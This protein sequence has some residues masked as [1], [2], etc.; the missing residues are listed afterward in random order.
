MGVVSYLLMFPLCVMK[1]CT[2][3]Y[4]EVYIIIHIFLSFFLSLCL[5]SFDVHAP[6]ES[7]PCTFVHRADLR[8]RTKLLGM[9]III[10][11]IIWHVYSS[12]SIYICIMYHVL[13]KNTK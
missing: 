5:G 4:G 8:Q 1:V 6:S 13:L 2:M 3:K 12:I 7:K 9:Y 11:I 10:I